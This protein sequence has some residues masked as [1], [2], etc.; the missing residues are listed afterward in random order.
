MKTPIPP[1]LIISLNQQQ[2]TASI[3]CVKAGDRIL[4]YQKIADACDGSSLD[5]HAPS[6]GRVSMIQNHVTIN[7]AEEEQLCIFIDTDGEDEEIENPERL[8]WQELQQEELIPIIA[9]AGLCGMG[10]AAFPISKKVEASNKREIHT[11]I[12]NAAECEPFITADQA[13]IRE[14]PHEV[15]LGAEILQH[16]INARDCFL[17]IERSKV[18]AI[19]ALTAAIEQSAIRL[20]ILDDKYPAGGERQVIQAVSG[21]E[22]PANRLPAEAGIHLQNVGSVYSVYKAVAEGRPCISRI[23]TLSGEALQTPKNFE[24]LIGTPVSYLFELCGIDN[25]AHAKTIVGGSMMGV[26]LMDTSAPVMQSSNC[27]I[28]GSLNEFPDSMPE[29]ACIRCGFCADVCPA[30]LLP[31]QLLSYSRSHDDQQLE[32][33]GLFDCIECGACAYVCPSNIQLLQYYRSSKE[34]IRQS[35]KDFETSKNWQNRFQYHQYRVKKL[36]DEA[37]SRTAVKS[38]DT[39]QN[40]QGFSKD[41]AV[42]E[43][44]AAVARVKARR[45]N[46][47]ASNA[48]TGSSAEEDNGGTLK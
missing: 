33:H 43:V 36:K 1:H 24:V 23:T 41:D 46:V 8:D 20:I 40:P 27:L 35:E 28:A 4:K 9:S 32:D 16:A 39:V 12:I 7:P 2:G 45:N 10:G 13:L 47:I 6:S 48:D 3:P 5:I 19:D 37:Q 18:D 34:Q 14:R 31:Q 11:L 21:K 15:I 38:V 26:E 25:K 44:A 30:G 42:L 22:L 29:Q 17:A